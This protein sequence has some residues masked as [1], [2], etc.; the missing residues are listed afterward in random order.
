VPKA[1]GTFEIPEREMLENPPELPPGPGGVGFMLLPLPDGEA[2]FD[3]LMRTPATAAAECAGA[4]L[5]CF[6]A[7]ERNWAG[8]LTVV[9]T[10]TSETPW[11]EDGPACCTE[12]CLRRYQE[13]RRGGRTNPAAFTAAIYEAPSCMPGLDTFTER[14]GAE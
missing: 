6:S 4:V 13:L 7:G 12:S 8:C 3:P 10:C 2:G 14:N 9:P 5:A 11:Q 1:I